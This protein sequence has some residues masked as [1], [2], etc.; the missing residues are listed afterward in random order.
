MSATLHEVF[1]ERQAR[2]WK[3]ISAAK[4]PGGDSL[5]IKWDTLG[6]FSE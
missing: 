3:L 5:L 4:D 1:N 2:C 6:S